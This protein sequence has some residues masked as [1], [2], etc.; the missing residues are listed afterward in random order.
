MTEL[1]GTMIEDI[2]LQGDSSGR[3][4]ATELTPLSPSRSCPSRP[5]SS[6]VT[7]RPV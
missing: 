1:R 7:A 3:S 6:G 2:K 4:G 5:R